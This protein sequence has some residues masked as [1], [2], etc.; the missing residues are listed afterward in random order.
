MYIKST[1][2]IREKKKEEVGKRGRG[3]ENR[4][5][6]CFFSNNVNKQVEKYYNDSLM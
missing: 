4:K 1:T 3:Q 5:E 2:E 6:K